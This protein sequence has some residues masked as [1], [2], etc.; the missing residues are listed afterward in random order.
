M[1][2]K[3]YVMT[4]GVMSL[5]PAWTAAQQQEGGGKK[6][7]V[8]SA[9]AM[10][11]EALAFPTDMQDYTDMNELKQQHANQP[12]EMAHSTG[13]TMGILQEAD[14]AG[15]VGVH[16]DAIIDEL[17]AVFRRH[18]IPLGLMNKLTMLSEL[19]AVHF[20]VDDSGSMN[21]PTD[22]WDQATG[23]QLTRWEEVRLRLCDMV[24]LLS[25]TPVQDVRVIFMNN[26]VELN[27]ARPKK[28]TA[29]AAYATQCVAKINAHFKTD[30][31]GATPA[32]AILRRSMRMAEGKSVA[33]YLLCDGVPSG[34]DAE[35]EL[36]KELIISRPSPANNP[37]TFLS[38]T[39]EDDQVEWMKTVDE[40]APYCAEV[41]DY[42]DECRE[43]LR[44]QGRGFPFSRG[45]HLLCQ[46]CGALNPFDLD[47][48]DE[49]VPFTRETL[50]NL[51]GYRLGDSEYAH[52]FQH[53]V[54]AQR[55]QS[56]TLA[57]SSEAA[58][59]VK[60]QTDWHAHYGEFLATRSAEDIPA[61]RAFRERM[62]SSSAGGAHPPP[63][64]A[65]AP[66]AAAG[67]IPVAYGVPVMPGQGSRQAPRA[68]GMAATPYT[69]GAK[70][71]WYK[72][73]FG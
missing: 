13:A 36:I 7:S 41:D 71:P 47:A 35:V 54:A 20:L 50:S 24:E 73:F 61:V 17:G 23:R 46:L 10:P 32:L 65:T 11:V 43:V 33:R 69:A 2:P 72:K 31:Y 28:S 42:Q 51:L 1:A 56:Q 66:H 45:F 62:R 63:Y 68:G 22:S 40:V 60:R 4:N 18:E 16:S 52:Y 55:A 8:P 30:P 64:S 67:S 70:E 44:D 39:N 26:S 27:F 37:F 14:Y 12:V 57:R 48:V 5:N 29:R 53:L 34:G 9:P 59:Q 21:A 15:A 19:D 6:S 38:C 3:K 49:W 25:F 58:D